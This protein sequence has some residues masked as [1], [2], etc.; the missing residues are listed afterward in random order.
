MDHLR[1][2]DRIAY[3]RFASVYRAFADIESFKEE[4]DA[5]VQGRGMVPMAQLPLISPEGPFA[6]AKSRTKGKSEGGGNHG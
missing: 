4:V 6:P 5:L 2:L 1:E 3:I